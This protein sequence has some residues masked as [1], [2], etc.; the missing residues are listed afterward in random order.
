MSVDGQVVSTPVV[1]SLKQYNDTWLLLLPP[2]SEAA[3]A[4][5]QKQFQ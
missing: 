5:I 4:G 3:I 1:Q 2:T